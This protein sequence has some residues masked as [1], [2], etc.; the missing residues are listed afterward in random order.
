MS[1]PRPWQRVLQ[2][3]FL[4][5]GGGFGIWTSEGMETFRKRFGMVLAIGP[6][7]PFGSGFGCIWWELSTSRWP[8]SSGLQLIRSSSCSGDMFWTTLS[9][10]SLWNLEWDN[11]FRNS[12][13]NNYDDANSKIVENR[14]DEKQL[15]G[16][17]RISTK[18]FRAKLKKLSR[19]QFS[20]LE[21][22]VPI[23]FKQQIQNM[24][25]HFQCCF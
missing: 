2:N 21:L 4:I 3:G 12:T 19:S 22:R 16:H 20:G 6:G 25:L 18:S 9:A 13:S 1:V 23:W 17:P 24:C 7:W 5:C 8:H 11:N 15:P 10:S 14:C